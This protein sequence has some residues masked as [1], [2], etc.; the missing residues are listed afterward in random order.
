MIPARERQ[1]R[2]A[3]L[4]APDSALATLAKEPTERTEAK[5]P[6]LPIDSA[7]P[8]D[9]MDNTE[10]VEPMDSSESREAM[11]H[12]EPRGRMATM[13]RVWVMPQ[14]KAIGIMGE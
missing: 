6:M 1:D 12:R 11:L 9:P 10:P 14:V 4:D 2:I 8:I 3:N 7:E 5:E 13:P